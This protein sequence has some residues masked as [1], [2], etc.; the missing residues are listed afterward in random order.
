MR[1]PKAGRLQ[2]GWNQETMNCLQGWK[3]ST[4]TSK[5]KSGRKKKAVIKHAMSVLTAKVA[6]QSSLAQDARPTKSTDV[7]CGCT[8]WD[9]GQND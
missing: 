2:W 6:W 1:L 8:E 9:K 5:Q 7:T 4:F 3:A